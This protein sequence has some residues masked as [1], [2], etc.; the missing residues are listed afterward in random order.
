MKAE[1]IHSEAQ[2]K[3]FIVMPPYTWFYRKLQFHQYMRY[4]SDLTHPPAL[5][6]SPALW[7]AAANC[8]FLGLFALGL[9]LVPKS[10][11]LQGIKALLP[12]IFQQT[13]TNERWLS[14]DKQHCSATFSVGVSLRHVVHSGLKFP[15]EDWGFRTETPLYTVE[16]FLILHSFLAS[17]LNLPTPVPVFPKIISK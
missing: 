13:S 8:M 7:L 6:A 16:T 1:M 15:I 5:W 4:S 9:S 12:H 2:W 14:V 11:K 17:S 10:H 3:G